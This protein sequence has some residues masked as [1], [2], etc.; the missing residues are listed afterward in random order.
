MAKNRNLIK[1]KQKRKV[2]PKKQITSKTQ[3]VGQSGQSQTGTIVVQ[4]D[5]SKKSVRTGDSQPKPKPQQQQP[6]IINNQQPL[7][8]PYLMNQQQQQTQQ[9]RNITVNTPPVNITN[10]PNTTQQRNNVD[11]AI[12]AFSKTTDEK[13]KTL[14]EQ[15]TTMNN[16]FRQ[17]SNNIM[18][19]INPQSY[20]NNDSVEEQSIP[21]P[22]RPQPT[23][24][25]KPS[26]T[27]II[28]DEPPKTPQ[29]TPPQYISSTPIRAIQQLRQNPQTKESPALNL[30]DKDLEDIDNYIADIYKNPIINP[31]AQTNKTFVSPKIVSNPSSS[32]SYGSSTQLDKY[33][34]LQY[35]KREK[36]KD[37]DTKTADFLQNQ[38]Y[39]TEPEVETEQLTEIKKDDIE[40]KPVRDSKS[41]LQKG[42][43]ANVYEKAIC[44]ICSKQYASKSVVHDHL[45]NHHKMPENKKDVYVRDGVKYKTHTERETVI[46][47][48]GKK[49]YKFVPTE[50][51]QLPKEQIKQII[52]DRNKEPL[53]KRNENNKV[54]GGKK[55]Q[56]EE[57]KAEKKNKS[58]TNK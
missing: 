20:N 28:N 31:N 12:N 41:D 14:Q 51:E 25:P 7:F 4:V 5:N 35:D 23:P 29:Q 40:D 18:E 36:D 32:V 21:T 50:Y 56:P 55:K 33:L 47:E 2:Q 9:P 19:R 16:N 54:I 17:A 57:P 45:N 49:T 44:P 43:Y 6:I 37:T 30:F 11:D 13:F 15:L 24:Q 42:I 22:P 48:D 3:R 27:I 58:T 46:K 53:E 39:E 52:E 10:P 34:Q 1:I 26:K 8:N 38:M